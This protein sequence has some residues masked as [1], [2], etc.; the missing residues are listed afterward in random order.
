MSSPYS[1]KACSIN[2]LPWQW[3]SEI[4]I[5]PV[6]SHWFRGK[7]LFLPY[8]WNPPKSRNI[9]KMAKKVKLFRFIKSFPEYSKL[10]NAKARSFIELA[11]SKYMSRVGNWSHALAKKCQ[12]FT[13]IQPKWPWRHILRASLCFKLTMI[14]PVVRS[15]HCI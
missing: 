13:L 12:L 10:V 4:T 5:V 7:R 14:C 9:E 8:A 15:V 2:L 11:T 1:L 6:Y 3:M